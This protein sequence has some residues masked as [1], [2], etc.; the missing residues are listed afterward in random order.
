MNRGARSVPGGVRGVSSVLE[1][2]VSRTPESRRNFEGCI[3]LKGDELREVTAA[4]SPRRQLRRS[5]HAR[6]GHA[7]VRSVVAEHLAN[8]REVQRFNYL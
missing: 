8:S 5:D 2:C 3:H 7:F 6:F 4:R 1:G